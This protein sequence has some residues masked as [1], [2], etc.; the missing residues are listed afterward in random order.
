[1]EGSCTARVSPETFRRC[2]GTY[3]TAFE[4]SNIG[5]KLRSSQI[6]FDPSQIRCVFSWGLS[7]VEWFHVSRM[8]K[9]DP[10]RRE[11]SRESGGRP[12]VGAEFADG[13]EFLFVANR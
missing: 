2:E 6:L 10:V 9:K 5:N 4:G 1:M 3:S 13:K 7:I 11:K 8:K 12:L